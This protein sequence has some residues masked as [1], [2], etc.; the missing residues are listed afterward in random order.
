MD[1]NNECNFIPEVVFL[2]RRWSQWTKSWLRPNDSEFV[3]I[4]YYGIH[5]QTFAYFGLQ[6]LSGNKEEVNGN[7]AGWTPGMLGNF[8]GSTFT[9]NQKG[10]QLFYW[11][12]DRPGV[13]ILVI[14]FRFGEIRIKGIVRRKLGWV[15]KSGINRQLF[16]Y[17]SRTNIFLQI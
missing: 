6:Q 12:I 15:K 2:V 16:L 13:F 3:A 10:N 1:I 5:K 4:N 11:R 7:T 9:I 17:C 14:W 8:L